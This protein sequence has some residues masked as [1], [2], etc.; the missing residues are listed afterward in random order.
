MNINAPIRY[1]FPYAWDKENMYGV[2]I[3]NLLLK[4]LIERNYPRAKTLLEHGATFKGIDSSTFGRCLFEFAEDYKMMKFLV[5]NG[6]N[7]INC[8]LEIFREGRECID[9]A[10]Y[11]WSLT[12]RALA[13]KNRNL[14]DM[15]FA[16]RFVPGQFWKN[17]KNFDM[18]KYAMNNDYIEL[19]EI[20]LSHGYPR[21]K[22]A[23]WID[24]G[25]R[26]NS[27]SYQYIMSSPV[28]QWKSYGLGD[29]EK[30]ISIPEKPVF[31]P[32]M[33][34]RTKE[35]LTEEYNRN[36]DYYQREVQAKKAYIQTLSKEDLEKYYKSKKSDPEVEKALKSFYA[37]ILEE[38]RKEALEKAGQ[39]AKSRYEN[40]EKSGKSCSSE[41]ESY[42][43]YEEDLRETNINQFSFVDA[44][45]NYRRWGDGFID[46][47]G[48]YVRW[49][50]A[51]VDGAGNYVQWGN[52]FVDGGGSYR[53]WGDDFVDGA[54]NYVRVP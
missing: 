26:S 2:P 36:V 23:F 16:N 33:L 14:L 45:G 13:L 34:S 30:E 54:G 11:G 28:V 15:L 29:L 47:K 6:F 38:G 7:G 22:L 32:L 37:E 4:E 52:S 8:Y 40:S 48:N 53:N 51:F 19:I 1:N 3:V 44:E 31:K 12:G 21:Q 46:C 43:S 18:V 27:K 17:G 5:D 9:R 49:G 25:A 24:N 20:L 10:G 50:S 35:R 42:K 39:R 41:E